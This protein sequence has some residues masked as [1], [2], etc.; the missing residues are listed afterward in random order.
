MI[1]ATDEGCK[2]ST[3]GMIRKFLRPGLEIREK[4]GLAGQT[5]S[6]IL[7]SIETPAP[8]ISRSMLSS[9]FRQLSARF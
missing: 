7:V 4:A 9:V 6:Y 8:I 2:L 5:H 1:D 3:E